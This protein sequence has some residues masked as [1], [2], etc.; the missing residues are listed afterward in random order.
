MKTKQRTPNYQLT[1]FDFGIHANERMEQRFTKYGINSVE[2]I[3]AVKQYF[4]KG[5]NQT[6]FPVVRK[7]LMKYNHQVAFYNQKLNMVIMAD[8]TTKTICSMF[9]LDGSDGYDFMKK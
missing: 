7:Q 6:H 1:D 8:P 2:D 9:Y 5:N 3:L 4:K